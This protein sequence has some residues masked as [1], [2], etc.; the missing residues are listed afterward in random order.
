MGLLLLLRGQPCRILRRARRLGAAIAIA[1]AVG[2]LTPAAYGAVSFQS[3]T[4]YSASTPWWIAS[5]DLN[6]DGAP[7]L[8]T[9]SGTTNI[10][11]ALL[12]SGTGSFAGPQNTAAAPSNLNAIA[13]GDL[14]G[15]GRS[16]VV[17]AQ[18]GAP[19]AVRV[20]L[21]N[22]DGTF[23]SSAPYPV[24][25][26]PQDVAIGRINADSALDLAIANQTTQD[27]SVLLNTGTGTF[28]AV[29]PTA[30][31]AGSDP[32]GVA[33]ADFNR[34]GI[35][36]LAIAAVNGSAGVTVL[37][38][39]GAGGF[40]ARVT[41]PRAAGAQKMVV[42]DLNGDGFPDIAATRPGVG[43]VAIVL[44]SAS[45][46]Q[47]ET[48]LN[49]DGPGGANGQLAI[50]DLDGDAALDLAVPYVLGPQANRLVILL[51]RGEGTFETASP[52][53]VG[54]EP[55]EVVAADLNRDGN[56]DLASS[57]SG[58]GDVS[59]LIA[60]PPGATVTPSLAF[61][62]QPPGATSDAH[63]ISVRNDGAQRLRPF[64][65]ALGGESAAEFAISTDA[66]TGASVRV[67][68]SCAIGVTF[69][70][71]GAGPRSATVA[72]TTNGSGS[73]HVVQLTGSGIQPP[74]PGGLLPGP[75]ANQKDGTA[76]ADVLTG[77]ASG[78][79]LFGLDGNDVL[80]GLAE[81]DCLIGGAGNDRLTGEAG[82]DRLNGGTGNDR[83]KDKDGKN[84]FKAGSG[85]DK[86]KAVNEQTETIK[87]G[88]GEDRATVDAK[89]K[90]KGCET[91]ARK[92][93]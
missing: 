87:C 82:D 78:D 49:P 25:N 62:D 27:V 19:G 42:G 90:V 18:T 43:D 5:A 44:N 65:V 60:T 36:D 1:A 88:G 73:P 54:A 9:A 7:D 40:A 17:V 61:G 12:G 15:D 11:S 35:T 8:A 77:T 70:P 20:Y 63:L 69:T 6:A 46:L 81:D 16:D 83:L 37:D 24:G 45:G 23:A 72:I 57:N 33:L 84:S 50:G 3:A 47:P 2:A 64:T 14:N 13:A 85:D 30:A 92:G 41:P 91:V 4:S 31:P 53:A 34:D 22:G 71:N 21:S 59:V 68:E 51:G 67:G 48:L 74:G 79:N 39:N 66:C 28:A 76:G 56:L 26:F 38:G 32:Q 29:P 55:R 10:V 89:D 58:A 75:C 52:L 80:N 86:I 93:R